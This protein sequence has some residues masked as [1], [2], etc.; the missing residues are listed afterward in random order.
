MFYYIFLCDIR[1][2]QSVMRAVRDR[3]SLEDVVQCF[4]L[5]PPEY[6]IE[7]II[8]SISLS[9]RPGKGRESSYDH[10]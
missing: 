7:S 3:T 6:D 4:H 9:I 2:F 8:F 10:A 1:S 5:S